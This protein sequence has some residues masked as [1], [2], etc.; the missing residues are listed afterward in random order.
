MGI[1][2]TPKGKAIFQAVVGAVVLVASGAMLF[3]CGG[4]NNSQGGADPRPTATYEAT[5]PDV[6]PTTRPQATPTT[7]PPAEPTA[8]PEPNRADCN[9][10]RGTSYQSGTEQAWFQA[11]CSGSG[12]GSSASSGGGGGGGPAVESTLGARIVIPS[13][14]VNAPVTST[15]VG[16]DGA[17]PDPVGYF[18]A[19]LYNFPSHPGLGGSN[20]ILAGHV[21]CARCQNGGPGT[22]VFYSVRNLGVGA[23]AQ[24]VNANGSVENYVVTASYELSANTDF[25]NIVAASTADMTLITCTGTFSGGHYNNRHVVA[26]RKA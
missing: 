16:A 21:D 7:I 4:S 22:A 18:N 10:I 6:A 20:K 26:F 2:S 23:T 13:A 11:N 8:V 19:V 12:G 15:S 3:A 25:T 9:A 14:G 5:G 17:M 24:W 1:L